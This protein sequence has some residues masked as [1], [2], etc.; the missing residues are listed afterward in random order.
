MRP[1]LKPVIQIAGMKNGKWLQSEVL[2]NMVK[3]LEA[4]NITTHCEGCVG[5]LGLQ[6]VRLLEHL[7]NVVWIINDKDSEKVNLYKI[8]RDYPFKLECAC[9][10]ILTT[11]QSL[12]ESNMIHENDRY[13]DVQ[14]CILQEITS[15]L[16]VKEYPVEIVNAAVTMLQNCHSERATTYTVKHQ[17]K[18]FR[19]KTVNIC[20]MSDLFRS[21]KSVVVTSEDL[22]DVIKKYMRKKNVVLWIDPPYYLSDGRYPEKQPG[23][24][25]HNR[26]YELLI[27]AKCRFVLFLRINT[28]RTAAVDIDNEAI[29][30]SLKSFYDNHYKGKNF[31]YR[32][33]PVRQ[34]CGYTIERVITNYAFDGCF[35]YK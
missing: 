5:G 15:E 27:K 6:P 20:P 19:K 23:W 12:T 1:K 24:C 31:Y 22:L 30:D 28:S 4:M 35:E 21:C 14:K 32:D 8:I 34:K 7:K 29:D 9:D 18:A 10:D 25:Y 26:I 2:P 33:M 17:C 13:L 16:Q 11:I 3:A